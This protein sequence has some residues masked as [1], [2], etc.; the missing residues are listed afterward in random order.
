MDINEEGQKSST[1]QLRDLV[2]MTKEEAAVHELEVLQGS[3]NVEELYDEDIVARVQGRIEEEI[4]YERF[5]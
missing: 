3:K 2:C 4:W 5:R 1:I